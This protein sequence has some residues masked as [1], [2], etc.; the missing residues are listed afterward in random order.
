MN[1]LEQ[2]LIRLGA[3]KLLPTESIAITQR[4][5]KK[6]I[7]FCVCWCNTFFLGLSAFL[8]VILTRELDKHPLSFI[9]LFASFCFIIVY[10]CS[11][12]DEAGAGLALNLLFFTIIPIRCYFGLGVNSGDLL[13]Y[14]G[15][16]TLAFALTGKRFG[17]F[18]L[19]WSMASIILLQIS[20]K[21]PLG[22]QVLVSYGFLR[23]LILLSTGI[24]ILFIIDEKTRMTELYQLWVKRRA[25]FVIMRRLGH[26]VGNALNIGMGYIELAKQENDLS[27]LEPVDEALNRVEDVLSELKSAESKVNLLE[28]LDKHKDAIRIDQKKITQV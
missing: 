10:L 27:L 9:I 24:P 28:F 12:E 21:P 22:E 3:P 20:V 18:V 16:T 11:S 23:L 25:G 2:L 7:I 19:L 5:V 6:R 14:L 26:E 4:K 1:W 15:H 17:L 8:S 13:Y